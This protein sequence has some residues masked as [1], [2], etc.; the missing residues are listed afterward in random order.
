MTGTETP[1][2]EVLAADDPEPDNARYLIESDGVWTIPPEDYHRD[3]VKGGSLSSSGVRKFIECAALGKAYIDGLLDESSAS[4]TLGSLAH[5]QVLD[6]GQGFDVRPID[7]ATGK[8]L[9]GNSNVYKEWKKK[10]E[11]AGLMVVTEDQA[12]TVAAM[13]K[14]LRAHPEASQMLDPD[15]IWAEQ[16]IVWTDPLGVR[17]RAMLDALPRWATQAGDFVFSDFK[18]TS[19]PNPEQIRK[20]I[21]KYGY[22]V[23]LAWYRRG[24]RALH[25]GGGGK[26]SA[27]LIFQGTKYPHIVTVVE[28]DREAMDWAEWQIDLA[29]ERYLRGQATG[30][31]PGYADRTVPLALPGWALRELEVQRDTDD[32]IFQFVPAARKKAQQ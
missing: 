17:G 25:L 31:W 1:D 19:D 7:K 24:V 12:K 26:V 6:S 32:D 23:Q 2:P 30:L 9:N 8:Q 14:A 15:S 5:A 28:P 16:T 20:D 18:T 22:H 21:W 3:P 27:R 4:L 10:T 11:A 29:L 13:V